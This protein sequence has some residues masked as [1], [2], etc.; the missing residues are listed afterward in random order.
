MADSIAHLAHDHRE[1]NR[2][3]LA[4]GAALRKLQHDR[5]ALATFT[6]VLS[7]LHDLLFLHFAREEEGLF[8]FLAESFPELAERVHEMTV[9]HDA[10]CGA[11][12]RARYFAT[13]T[14]DVEAIRVMYERFEI[15][16]AGHA[17]Q[18]AALLHDVDARLDRAQRAALVGL[19]DDL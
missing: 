7:N 15:S 11:L 10:I 3:V 14:G 13:G 12:T 17:S 16:Y 19:I 5:A 18:E 2:Q 8:P 1:I 6:A 4:V 9:A